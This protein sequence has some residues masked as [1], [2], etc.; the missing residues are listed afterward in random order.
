MREAALVV[1]GPLALSSIA[2]ADPAPAVEP[3]ASPASA[4]APASAPETPPPAAASSQPAPAAAREEPI[5]RPD[6]YFYAEGFLITTHFF[7]MDPAA[8]APD[9]ERVLVRGM[10]AWAVPLHVTASG[11]QLTGT[12]LVEASVLEAN[13][14]WQS[15]DQ[16]RLCLGLAVTG[17]RFN[18]W[19]QVGRCYSPAKDPYALEGPDPMVGFASVYWAYRTDNPFRQYGWRTDVNLQPGA[20]RLHLSAMLAVDEAALTARGHERF[21]LDR[22]IGAFVWRFPNDC[23]AL[24][25]INVGFETAANNYGGVH[26]ECALWGAWEW[27]V[28]GLVGGPHNEN[29][30]GL[31]VLNRLSRTM[32][33]RQNMELVGTA[34]ISFLRWPGAH[35]KMYSLGGEGT[36]RFA[37]GLGMTAGAFQVWLDRAALV[38]GGRRGM[39]ETEAFMNLSWLYE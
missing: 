23:R 25:M 5:W 35:G 17:R 13:G 7:P 24:G 27:G 22:A 26:A 37:N 36:W 28:G 29:G 8:A 11:L 20:T 21:A 31:Q 14:S 16:N 39:T 1:L 15:F 12:S 19:N 10:W 34:T 33:D 30:H 2:A 3:A 18:V 6:Q 32:P 9:L 38:E 4:A